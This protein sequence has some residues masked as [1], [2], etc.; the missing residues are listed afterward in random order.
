VLHDVRQCSMLQA[1]DSP[2]HWKVILP[3][4]GLP[5]LLLMYLAD[6]LDEA[7]E[8]FSASSTEKHNKYILL[9]S[10]PF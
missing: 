8:L 1:S 6:Y 5:C 9:L 7:N 3:L 10:S 2:V 4:V